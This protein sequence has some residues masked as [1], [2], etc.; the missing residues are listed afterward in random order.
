M[1]EKGCVTCGVPQGS[2]LGPLLFLLFI[3]ELPLCLS[4][5]AFSIDLYADDTTIYDIQ[6]D[7]DTLVKN[8]QRAL[9][10]LKDWCRQNGMILNTQKTKVML[11]S[12]RQKR[13]HIDESIFV[14]NYNNTQLQ[15]TT[16]DKILGINIEQNMQWNDH[17]QVVCKKMSS[18]IWLL[19]RISSY[20]NSEYRL[21]FY[22]AYIVP[23][24]NYCNIIW[25]NS[26]NTNVA[27]I[28]KLQKRAFKTILGNE[29]TDFEDAKPMLNVQSFEESLFLNKAKI[30]Y[31]I[32]NNLVPT[33]VCDLFQRR[34]D[35]RI[36]TTLRSV[37]NENFVLPKPS[38]S[39]FKESLSYS[40]AVIWNSIPYEVKNSSSLNCFVHNVMQW[41]NGS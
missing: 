35:S 15:V 12:T 25:G 2:I 33:Y 22:K 41:M 3:N 5:Y 10:Y 17:F 37:S 34:S 27:K 18:Y 40:G 1:S 21:M 6:N 36:N 26:S 20:L 23:H 24:L 39:I 30:M 32:A 38:L 16:C 8:L 7:L 29:Y 4:E 11:L 28:T 19:S 13:L 31:R 14:L 9:D